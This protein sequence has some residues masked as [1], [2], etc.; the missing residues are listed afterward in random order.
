MKF[1]KTTLL[2]LF[3][4]VSN[5]YAQKLVEIDID[6][7]VFPYNMEGM[8]YSEDKKAVFVSTILGGKFEE[9]TDESKIQELGKDVQFGYIE[10]SKVFYLRE[11]EN[12]DDEMY[13]LYSFMKKISDNQFINMM[14]GFPLNEENIYDKVVKKAA[15]SAKT[16]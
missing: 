6:E 7:K 14:T 4:T 2:I 1:L 16:N 15:L 5:V 9:M 13:L 12:R 8:Y 3:F 11:E 10:N